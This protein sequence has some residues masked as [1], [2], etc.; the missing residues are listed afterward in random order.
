METEIRC[1]QHCSRDWNILCFTIPDVCPLCG[2]DT[3]TTEM[4]IP[5]YLIQS[6]LTD[7]NTTQCCVVI[8]PTIGCFLTD[9]TNQSN[10]HIAV[11]NTAGVVYEFDERGVTV[12]GSDWTQCLRVN[13]LGILSETV[14]KKCDETLAIMAQNETWTKEKY[15]EFSHNCYDFV[16]QF[17]RNISNVVKTGCLESRSLFCEQV[18]VPVTSKAGKYISMY[19]TVAT[20]GYIIQRVT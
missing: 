16:M 18:I 5:P 8:K 10:L 2:H 9:Y 11:T 15:N 19:R 6:P 13:V 7:A 20:D 17:L 4:R 12:G 1:F 3:M 14:Y